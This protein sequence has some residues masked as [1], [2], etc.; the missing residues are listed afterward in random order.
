MTFT[1]AQLKQRLR[2]HILFMP[3]SDNEGKFL[4]H[5]KFGW[6]P[7]NA[8]QNEFLRDTDN[9]PHTPIHSV[10]ETPSAGRA[11]GIFI[12]DGLTKSAKHRRPSA[13]ATPEPDPIDDLIEDMVGGAGTVYG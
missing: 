5:M 12:V 3:D 2:T 9:N 7:C 1:K 6:G 10:M 11:F 13:G 8:E 4:Y